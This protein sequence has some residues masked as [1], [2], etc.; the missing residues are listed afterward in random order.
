M[1]G[2]AVAAGLVTVSAGLLLYA[3]ASPKQENNKKAANVTTKTDSPAGPPPT[4]D[5][6]VYQYVASQLNKNEN[7]QKNLA[8]VKMASG[9]EEVEK[10]IRAGCLDALLPHV[11]S[12]PFTCLYIFANAA[13][14][15]KSHPFFFS[16]RVS[17]LK[18]LAFDQGRGETLR[19]MLNLT[20]QKFP[21]QMCKSKLNILDVLDMCDDMELTVEEIAMVDKIRGNLA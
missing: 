14:N 19:L 18:M 2:V 12:D 21:A 7:V 8:L 17:L 13:S 11:A 20:Y 16:G 15:P 4:L 10:V 6:T 1:K 5:L 9:S 3:W